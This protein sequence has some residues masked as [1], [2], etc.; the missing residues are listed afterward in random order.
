MTTAPSTDTPPDVAQAEAE[1]TT[2][3]QAAE[4]LA[5]RVREGDEQVTAEQLATAQQ[6][7]VFARLRAEA[8]RR[9]A[10][11]AAAKAEEKRRQTLTAEAVALID[12]KADPRKVAEAY[13]AAREALTALLDA[14][15]AHDDAM[16]QAAHLLRQAGAPAIRQVTS[17]EDGYARPGKASRTA[18][19]VEQTNGSA[20]VS[21]EDGRVR[22]AVGT[23]PV[24][25]TL[26]A[27]VASKAVMPAGQ[28]Q[29]DR[30]PLAEQ[31][32]RHGDQV[33]RFLD[34]AAEV[35]K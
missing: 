12:D 35:A 32:H 14:T 17:D 20:A 30:A 5:E 15:Q 23:G 28:S 13:T 25:V 3:E 16:G 9:K 27:E 8:A 29:F 34:R 21:V 24:L 1:A 19:T 7:G 2:A 22:N 4:A 10:D 26:L 33:R 6:A 31:E 11:R 18:P